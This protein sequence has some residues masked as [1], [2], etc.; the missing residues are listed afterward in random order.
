[1]EQ[2]FLE[3]LKYLMTYFEY[4]I[5]DLVQDVVD[6]DALDPEYSAVTAENLI[7][8]YISVAKEFGF[9]LPYSD[10]AS[11]FQSCDYTSEEYQTFVDRKK[12]E[13]DYY[14]GRQ[15]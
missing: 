15:F 3:K 11:Y 10:V 4:Y 5:D 13:S 1:M 9:A 7:K 8:C 14:I 12:K 6:D 2:D